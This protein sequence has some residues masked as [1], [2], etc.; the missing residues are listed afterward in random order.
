[1]NTYGAG[2]YS[3]MEQAGIL[4]RASFDAYL[5]DVIGASNSTELKLDGFVFEPGM[6]LDFDYNQLQVENNIGVMA[7]YVDKDSEAIPLGTKGFETSKGSIPRQKAFHTMDEDD[8][9]KYLIAMSQIQFTGGT[10]KSQALDNLF[11]KMKELQDS[12]KNSMTYQRDSMISRAGLSLLDTNNPRG[13]KN[14]TF[15][16]SVPDKNKTTL[17][18]NDRWFTDA[19][20]KVEGSTSDPVK[21][22]KKIIR[23][24]KRKNT[25]SFHIE[26]DEVSFL[27]DMEHSKWKI[28]LG[29]ST[30]NQI[31]QNKDGDAIAVGIANSMMDDEIKRAFSKVVGVNVVYSKSVVAVEKWN[32]ETKSLERPQMRSFEPD[33]YVFVPDGTVG[34]IKTVAPLMPD[35]TGLYGKIFDGRGIIKYSYDVKTMVQEWWSELTCLCVPNKSNDMYYL[36]TK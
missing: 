29:R 34:T 12:H 16:A 17:T 5:K 26:V 1:M 35:S 14:I 28:A 23:E 18:G 4:N 7:T 19:D 3:L 8:Y 21:N 15:D 31:S 27:D 32:K 30:N 36:K 10:T 24:L 11:S 25:P 13:I 20:K 2:F 33:T 22:M 9:R 6:Q